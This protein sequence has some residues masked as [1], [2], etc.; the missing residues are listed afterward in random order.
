MST[1][2]TCCYWG[3][4]QMPR[5]IGWQ[6]LPTFH[7]QCFFRKKTI[8]VVPDACRDRFSFVGKCL[9]VF[10]S[11]YMYLLHLHVCIYIYIYIYLFI[12]LFLYLFIDLLIF[13]YK[14]ISMHMS[15]H[16]SV[17]FSR[18]GPWV[19]TTWSL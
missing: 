2:W 7:Y 1:I 17:R 11:V 5:K 9:Y 19:W 16:Y 4:I 8:T 18:R 6:G 10:V 13:L 3:P 12:D 15:F 14:C